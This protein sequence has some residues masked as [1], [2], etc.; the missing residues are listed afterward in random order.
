M[1]NIAQLSELRNEKWKT[2]ERKEEENGE[3]PDHV[4]VRA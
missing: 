4:D 3:K 2:R 1:S